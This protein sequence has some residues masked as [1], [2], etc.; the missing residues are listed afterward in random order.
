MGKR[1]ERATKTPHK[2]AC[3]CPACFYRRRAAENLAFV[4]NTGGQVRDAETM[5]ELEEGLRDLQGR[6]RVSAIET[7]M[8]RSSS[9]APASSPT[10]PNSGSPER[11]TP[12][13]PVA[14]S[15]I[16]SF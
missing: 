8:A 7:Q 1:T 10:A 14:R 12:T 13:L 11:V 9:S 2:P 5:R 3:G 6:M 15:Q 16:F 4:E